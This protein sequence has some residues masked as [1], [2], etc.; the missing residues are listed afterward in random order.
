MGENI[1]STDLLMLTAFRMSWKHK[2]ANKLLK[3]APQ[4]YV[5]TS[6]IFFR[7]GWYPKL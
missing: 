3:N 5:H 4:K 1:V 6:S 7:S 2:I